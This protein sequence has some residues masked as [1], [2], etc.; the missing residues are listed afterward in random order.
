VDPKQCREFADECLR[1][2]QQARTAEHRAIL[3]GMSESWSRMAGELE[4]M[5]AA[6]QRRKWQGSSVG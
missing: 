2:S 1:M 6:P 5:T 3:I 4:E